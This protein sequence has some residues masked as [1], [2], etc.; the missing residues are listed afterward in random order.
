MNLG[1]G[2]LPVAARKISECVAMAKA[3]ESKLGD[4]P[5][6]ATLTVQAVIDAHDEALNPRSWK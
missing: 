1:Q 3:S 6:P 2:P 5:L 4:A